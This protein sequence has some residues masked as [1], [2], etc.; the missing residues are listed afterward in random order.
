LTNFGVKKQFLKFKKFY[1]SLSERFKTIFSE[2]II[3]SSL[4]EIIKTA[5]LEK[6]KQWKMFEAYF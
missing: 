6:N 3:K 5:T 4:L 1:W 2:K